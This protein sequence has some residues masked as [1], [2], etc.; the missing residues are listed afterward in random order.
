MRIFFLF[1]SGLRRI[2]SQCIA[3]K[4]VRRMKEISMRQSSESR[5]IG[6]RGIFQVKKS[7]VR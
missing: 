4:F 5:I 7:T 2:V 1:F 3:K 6:K